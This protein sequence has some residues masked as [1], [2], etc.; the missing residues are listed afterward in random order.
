MKKITLSILIIILT[1]SMAGI[2]F[3]SDITGAEYKTTITITNNSTAATNVAV[4][5]TL[6]TPDMIAV[7]MLSANASDVAIISSGGSDTA[8][9]PACDNLTPWVTWVSSIGTDS[10]VMQFL[11]T[12]GVTGGTICYFPGDTGMSANHSATLE[13]GD[14]WTIE[15][16]GWVDTTNGAGKYLIKKLGAFETCISASGNITS[17]IFDTPTQIT[18][19][20]GGGSMGLN[21]VYKRVGQTKPDFPYSVVTEVQFYLTRINS[22]TGTAYARIRDYSDDSIIGTLGSVD[23]T[24]ITDIGNEWVSFNATSVA[25]TE[26]TNVRFS[27]E[28]ANGTSSNYVS[29]Y[30]ENSNVVTGNYTAYTTSW[31]DDVNKDLCYKITYAPANTTVTATG[32]SSG[33]HTVTTT[34]NVTNVAIYVD[35]VLKDSTALTA[36]VTDNDNDWAYYQNMGG[37]W[38]YTKITINGTLQQHIEWEYNP[39]LFTDL[40][41]NDHNAAPTFRTTSSNANVRAEVTQQEGLLTSS[42]PSSNVSGGWTMIPTALET[43]EDLFTE[44]GDAYAIGDFNTGELVTDYAESAGHPPE[45]YHFLLAYGIALIVILAVYGFTHSSRLGRQGS[46]ALAFFAGGLVLV[47][48]YRFETIPG[49]TLIPY[50]LGAILLIMW[51][52]S[53]SPVD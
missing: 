38:E 12:K 40:S 7:G 44:G 42:T 19:T 37:Y 24:T 15:Q 45:P 28:Y 50:G 22:P 2:A 10:Q 18:Q 46:L 20:S 39:S 30:R 34:A 17:S 25:I 8:F 35:N 4:P 26:P 23:V 3:A 9:M 13:L 21:D 51:R 49:W 41:G 32:I 29:V 31:T 16:K 27:L 52:R 53:P 6:S 33:I 47:G 5:F 48:F 1:L 43:P 14:N 36:N 11:Y